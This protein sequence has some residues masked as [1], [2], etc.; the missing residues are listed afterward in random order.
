MIDSGVSFHVTSHEDLF[1]SYTLGD[2]GHVRMG[3]EGMSKIVG[4]RDVCLETNTGC[5]L[6]LKDVRHVP[7]IRLNLISTGKLDDEGYKNQFGNGKWKLSKGSLIVA[8]GNKSSTLYMMQAK[9]SK[10]E[11]NAVEKEASAE[12]RHK[13]LVI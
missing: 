1:T 6:V 9:L 8:R 13:G 12:L 7:D 2:F 3:N 5:R 4:M 11:V 10:G